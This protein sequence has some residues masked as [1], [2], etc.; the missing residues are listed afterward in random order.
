MFNT[1][2]HHI[3]ITSIDVRFFLFILLFLIQYDDD[4]D[5]WPWNVGSIIDRLTDLSIFGTVIHIEKTCV[6]NVL[7]F[8][9]YR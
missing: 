9:Q 3:D 4:D 7:S 1:Y 8:H 5:D 6:N 2:I